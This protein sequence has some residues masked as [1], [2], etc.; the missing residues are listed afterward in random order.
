MENGQKQKSIKRNLLEWM[1]TFVAG[2][3]IL[4]LFAPASW[5]QFGV[6]PVEERAAAAGMSLQKMSS[7]ERWELSDHAG[8]VVVVNYWATWCPPC[9]IETP[10]FVTLANEFK[11]S[12]V[13]FVGVTMDD[14][15]SLVPP[16]IESYKIPYVMLLPGGDPNLPEGGI[17]LPTTFLYDKTGRLAKK[18][19][20][21]VLESTLRSDITELLEESGV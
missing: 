13:T 14:D 12:G 1:G 8:K 6:S 21:M 3:I 18:Y 10:G 16:F 5:W 4:F 17:A 7:D 2:V 9:R 15:L 19:T 20:G 11:D